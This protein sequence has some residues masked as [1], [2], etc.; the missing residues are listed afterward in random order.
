MLAE[1]QLRLG[2]ASAGLQML[3]ESLPLLLEHAP[4]GLQAH[5]LLVVGNARLALA[6][7]VVQEMD[8][9]A[10]VAAAAEALEHSLKIFLLI[11]AYRRAKEV[12]GLETRQGHHATWLID[13][14]AVH[15][16]TNVVSCEPI[17]KRTMHTMTIWCC[18]GWLEQVAYLLARA[19]HTLLT[20]KA[21]VESGVMP[22]IGGK[23]MSV[24]DLRNARNR[25][26]AEVRSL[27]AI[28]QTT[29]GADGK[30]AAAAAAA[31]AQAT[32]QDAED[33]HSLNGSE[34]R[35][36]SASALDVGA[37]EAQG[38]PSH[39]RGVC[40][41]LMDNH[42]DDSVDGESW[43]SAASNDMSMMR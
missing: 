1:I 8:A 23:K 42:I 5:A 43:I 21:T 4:Y 35:A 41:F 34:R 14:H 12:R 10:R 2:A 13:S 11:E 26:A 3:H 39:V 7:Q 20:S 33:D 29:R 22:V 6:S 25:N 30:R 18:F 31:A 16:W 15:T 37:L 38:G 19:Y 40:E 28:L 24:D 9:Q 17:S 32:A 27:A 36:S